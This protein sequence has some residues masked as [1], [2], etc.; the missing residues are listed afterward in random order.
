MQLITATILAMV[1]GVPALPPSPNED[2][3]QS[4]ADNSMALVSQSPCGTFMQKAVCCRKSLL[5]VIDMGCHRAPADIHTG[6]ELAAA[7][8]AKGKMPRC[9]ILG[10]VSNPIKKPPFP[11]VMWPGKREA[12]RLKEQVAD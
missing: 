3:V 6:P 1:A 9:C 11:L 2:L 12:A 7:C 4:L 10:L 5:G 8:E